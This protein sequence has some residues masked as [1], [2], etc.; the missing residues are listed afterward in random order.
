MSLLERHS[1]NDRMFA[2]VGKEEGEWRRG[3]HVGAEDGVRVSMGLEVA[4][5]GG[6]DMAQ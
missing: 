1:G 4:G 2:R 6:D 3:V 5:S